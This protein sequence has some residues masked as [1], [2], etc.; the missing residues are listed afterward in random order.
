[1]CAPPGKKRITVVVTTDRKLI[2]FH[3]PYPT[4]CRSRAAS[5][6]P[7]GHEHEEVREIK[8]QRPKIKDQ[9]PKINNASQRRQ[10]HEEERAGDGPEH[11]DGKGGG[12]EAKVY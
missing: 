7:G 10:T 2:L 6:R 12:D 11:S 4:A 8:D 1:M 3:L 5:S 9:R